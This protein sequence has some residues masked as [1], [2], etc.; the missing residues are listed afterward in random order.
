MC[1]LCVHTLEIYTLAVDEHHTVLYLNGAETELCREYHLLVAGSILLTDNDGIEVWCLR[2]PWQQRRKPL[3]RN[4]LLHALYTGSKLHSYI[5]CC[6]HLAV[7]SNKFHLYDF[8]C[9][10]TATVIYLKR[11]IHAATVICSIECACNIMVRYECLW[12]SIEIYIAVHTAHV[13]HILSLKIRCIAPTEHLHTDVVLAG[14]HMGTQV[15]LVVV[16]STLGITY[17][18]TVHP[19]ECG[20][21][22]TVEMQ[23]HV[24]CIP[25]LG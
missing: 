8:A 1:I 19:H 15:K 5:V 12:C 18:F 14:A 23:E 25:A 4:I 11:D 24:L 17:I 22:E 16:V 7:G 20:T 10:L 13:E 9:S 3:K 2:S 6:Y 21:V